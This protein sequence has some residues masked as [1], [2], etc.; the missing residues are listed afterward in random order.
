MCTGTMIFVFRVILRATS[1]GS[2]LTVRG[3]TSAKTS[4]APTESGYATVAMNVFVGTITS[5]PGPTPA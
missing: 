3:S 4:F 1:F 5:S 2:M